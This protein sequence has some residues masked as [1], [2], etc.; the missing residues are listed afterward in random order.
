MFRY[1]ETWYNRTRKQSALQYLSPSEYE[2]EMENIFL[3]KAA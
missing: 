2:F 3:T 1:I